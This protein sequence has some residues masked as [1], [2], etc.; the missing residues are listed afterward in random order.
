MISQMH[1]VCH[2]FKILDHDHADAKILLGRRH[3]KHQLQLREQRIQR[4]ARVNHI[5][6]TKV[7][8][9]RWTVAR[10]ISKDVAKTAS[11]LQRRSSKRNR[12]VVNQ[13]RPI[14]HAQ[15]VIPTYVM[16]NIILKQHVLERFGAMKTQVV[17][18]ENGLD[19]LSKFDVDTR[20]VNKNPG[21]HKVR[22]T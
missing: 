21:I 19:A 18:I 6:L 9:V 22:L 1:S 13:E 2:R 12:D 10:G 3:S 11:G 17:N 20:V 8:H 4:L 15:T 5:R 7:S 14:G 16:T